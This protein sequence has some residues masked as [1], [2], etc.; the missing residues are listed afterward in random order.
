MRNKGQLF[1]KLTAFL[2][3]WYLKRQKH[4]FHASIYNKNSIII[5]IILK[6][7]SYETILATQLLSMEPAFYFRV[8]IM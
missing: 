2:R 8:W 3:L 1:D 7:G 5:M 6:I 4:V